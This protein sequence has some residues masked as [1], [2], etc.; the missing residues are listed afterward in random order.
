M[1]ICSPTSVAGEQSFSHCSR[2][3][4]D[5]SV[6]IDAGITGL[7]VRGAE[8]VAQQARSLGFGRARPIFVDKRY[9]S[10]DRSRMSTITFLTETFRKH[11]RNI[12]ETLFVSERCSL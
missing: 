11:C 4:F 7:I 1:F 9:F 6:T 10:S 2:F 12:F 3:S 5:F 8:K